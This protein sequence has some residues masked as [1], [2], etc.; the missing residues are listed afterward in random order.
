MHLPG[1]HKHCPDAVASRLFLNVCCSVANGTPPVA[2]ISCCCIASTVASR[3]ATRRSSVPCTCHAYTATARHNAAAAAHRPAVDIRRAVRCCWPSVST[4]M[5]DDDAVFLGLVSA[6]CLPPP[7]TPR[8]QLLRCSSGLPRHSL[9]LVGRAHALSDLLEIPAGSDRRHRFEHYT[10]GP[11]GDTRDS[12]RFI[13]NG[14]EEK[15]YTKLSDFFR[16]ARQK[17]ALTKTDM[18]MKKKICKKKNHETMYF[19]YTRRKHVTT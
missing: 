1:G 14:G 5:C 9:L 12:R 6:S 11:M 3:A 13:V 19:D 4:A 18:R 2:A 8:P 10:G 17:N 16:N 15:F 7:A